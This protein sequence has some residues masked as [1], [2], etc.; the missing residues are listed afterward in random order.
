MRN[1]VY[2][3]PPKYSIFMM[4]LQTDI[5]ILYLENMKLH[6]ITDTPYLR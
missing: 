3:H 6:R 5:R 2:K 1:E 4:K